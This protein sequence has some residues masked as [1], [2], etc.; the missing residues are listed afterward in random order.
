MD[1]T[2]CSLGDATWHANADQLLLF[3]CFGPWIVY[4][5]YH[6]SS[7]NSFK[8]KTK[9]PT[10]LTRYDT[11]RFGQYDNTS[12]WMKLIACVVDI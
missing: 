12:E 4:H 1:C 11:L 6:Y 2:Y 8:R 10:K 7:S 3:L 9:A 5:F